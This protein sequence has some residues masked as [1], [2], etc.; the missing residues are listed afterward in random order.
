[1]TNNEHV[2]TDNETSS[3][4]NE[5][6]INEVSTNISQSYLDPKILDIK[7]ARKN[8]KH[9]SFLGDQLSDLLSS[10]RIIFILLIQ[11]NSTYRSVT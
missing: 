4:S 9:R 10:R 11:N 8:K 6:I 1:M 3:D 2:N 7:N 5:V